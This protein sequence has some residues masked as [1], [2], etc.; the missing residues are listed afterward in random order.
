MIKGE[1]FEFSVP[2]QLN[3]GSYYLDVNLEAGRGDKTAIYYKDRT[4]SFLDLW[5]LTNR[6]GNVFKGLGVEPENRVLLI[7]EDSPEWVAAWLAAM[8]IGAVG[9]HAYTY[10]M[11]H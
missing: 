6:V 2:E 5:R 8:K 4:Y 3:L 11:P 10:L 9:T 1:Q 7:L